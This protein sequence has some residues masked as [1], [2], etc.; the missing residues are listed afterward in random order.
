MIERCLDPAWQGRILEYIG[1]QYLQVPFFYMN[2]K[3]YGTTNENVIVWAD[4]VDGQLL[5]AYLQYYDCLHFFTKK[6]SYPTEKILDMIDAI[7]PRV[8]IVLGDIG[9][10]IEPL[11]GNAYIAERSYAIDL[12]GMSCEGIRSTVEL[13]CEEDLEQFVD[14]M[15]NDPEYRD[16]YDRTVLCNQLRARFADHF[17]RFFLIRKEGKIAAVYSTYGE[18][19]QMALVS[20]LLVHPEYRR[21]GLASDI[22]RYACSMLHDEGKRCI[23]FINTQNT[24]SLELHKNN[25]ATVYSALCKFVK[26]TGES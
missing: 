5:G 6:C 20:G 23:G 2:L 12:T 13:A 9:N 26:K 3:Q 8:V 1:D 22:V 11:L 18:T 19:E 25:G 7:G 24:A 16:T 17:S 21:Q 4:M 15:L 14:L 10:Q